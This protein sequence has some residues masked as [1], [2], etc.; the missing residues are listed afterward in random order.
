MP[1]PDKLSALADSTRRQIFENL[2]AGGPRSVADIARAFPVSRPAVS[3]HLKVLK[4]AGLVTSTEHGARHLY[5]ADPTGVA[6]F[7]DYLDSLW[8]RALLSFREAA[9][10]PV[11]RKKTRKEKKR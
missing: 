2:V 10:K 11:S 3:Q 9:E 5:C 7:R 6:E 4:E 8:Q 1:L